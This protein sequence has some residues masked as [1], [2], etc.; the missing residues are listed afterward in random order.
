MLLK[1]LHLS[2]V[3]VTLTAFKCCGLDQMPRT[4]LNTSGTDLKIGS[5]D[6]AF[7]RGRRLIENIRYKTFQLIGN[8]INLFPRCEKKLDSVY[9]QNN[10]ELLPTCF[11]GVWVCQTKLEVG[12]VS[13][14]IKEETR[15]GCLY[16]TSDF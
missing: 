2:P 15:V 7:F 4:R 9:P 10:Q 14:L 5:F 6:P 8:Y 1:R 12:N 13:F 3:L 11:T 16:C